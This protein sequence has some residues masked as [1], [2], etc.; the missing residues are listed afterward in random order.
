[1]VVS[2]AIA[3]AYILTD[4]E[5]DRGAMQFFFIHGLKQER[6]NGPGLIH[7]QYYLRWMSAVLAANV[8]LFSGFERVG[9]NNNGAQL[10]QR[11][12]APT[13]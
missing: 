10:L 12:K 3:D 5:S 6:I 2:R 4:E 11:A 7:A 1:M 13:T 9:H 8:R